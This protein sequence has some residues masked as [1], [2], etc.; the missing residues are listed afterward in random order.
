MEDKKCV[1]SD[2][3]YMKGYIKP[4]GKGITHGF[5]CIA[6]D[7]CFVDITELVTMNLGNCIDYECN[8]PD[9]KMR[10]EAEESEQLEKYNYNEEIK[11]S[12]CTECRYFLT[13]SVKYPSGICLVREERGEPCQ[14]GLGCMCNW[15]KNREGIPNKPTNVQ[16]EMKDIQKIALQY[17]QLRDKENKEDEDK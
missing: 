10:I 2:C 11:S 4:N 14:C 8:N 16:F 5:M 13:D 6:N 3:K 1:C 17:E 7:R 12:D 15:Y 9:W